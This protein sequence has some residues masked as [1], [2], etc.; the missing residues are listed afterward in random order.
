LHER[1]Q[2]LAQ[3]ECR[4]AAW[5]RH[6]DRQLFSRFAMNALMPHVVFRRAAGSEKAPIKAGKE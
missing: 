3:S 2:L 4:L 6:E 1:Q 5:L